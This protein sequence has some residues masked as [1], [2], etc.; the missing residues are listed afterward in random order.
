MTIECP[1]CQTNNPD[2]VKFCGECGTR[3]KLSEEEPL[4]TRT[5]EAPRK[6]L[7]SG[8]LFARRFQIIEVLGQGGMGKVYRAED[9]KV[10]EEVALKVI[11]PEISTDKKTIERF[12]DEL[13]LARK[14]AHRNVCKMYD[15]NEFSGSYYITMEYIAGQDLKALIRQT[16][17]LTIGKA[18]SVAGQVCEG[19]IEAHRLGIIHR[20]LKPSNIMID[21]EGNARIMDFGIARSLTAKR[22]TGSGMMLGTPEYMSPEQVDGKE[23]DQCSDI[24][25]MG[26]IL[27]EM[28]T[29]RVPFAGDTALSIAVKQKSESPMDPSEYNIRIPEDLSRLI[30]KCL[31]KTISSRFQ[32]AEQI[33]AELSNIDSDLT[34]TERTSIKKEPDTKERQDSEW[35]NSIAVLPFVDLSPQ[36]DQ[37]YFCDGMAE[38]L[39]NSLTKI[40][41]LRVVARTSAFAFKGE[42][43]DIREIGQK[44]NVKTVLEGS[45]RKAGNKL[46]IMAQLINIEDGFHIWS[47]KYDRD[48]DDV[49]AIQD[50][51]SLAIVDNLKGKLL[52]EEKAKLLKR[53]AVDVEAY[54]L[55]LKGLYF[56]NKRTKEGMEKGMKHFEQA[57]ELDPSYAQAYS[58]LADSFTLLSFWSFLP[59]KE[60]FPKAKALAEKALEIDGSLAEAHVSLAYIIFCYEWDWAAVEKEFKMA[61]QLNPGLA[62]AHHWYS[63]YLSA[64][65]R[66]EEALFEIKKALDLDPMSLMINMNVGTIYHHMRHYDKAVEVLQ[67]TIEMNP[68]FGQ[69]YYSLA[70][71]YSAMGKYT[72]SVSASLTAKKQGILW[73]DAVLGLAYGR[74][75]QK[76]KARALLKELKVLSKTRFVPP[77]NFAAI[78]VGLG[79]IDTAFEWIDKGFDEHETVMPFYKVAPDF[80]NYRSDP[81]FEK[82][83]K[84]LN[85]V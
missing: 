18:L 38:E 6:P 67:K 56:W 10:H 24:Y 34:T 69:A 15:L 43:A 47:D 8:D 55:Y 60:G 37:E 16:G 65:E 26:I 73:A 3:F 81:R 13:K 52:G 74:A 4:H 11:N 70:K 62:N 12:R 79:E 42:K 1:K 21:R 14:I 82:L 9:K 40:E 44:L 28:V 83:L 58:G 80:D 77:V 23:V 30:L 22:R 51:I 31:N 53:Q 48:M 46:R 45:V 54:K 75:G 66:H 25:S 68:N 59:P 35:K 5:L 33:L 2:T 64:M 57:I 39:I 41:D 29:G 19:L 85:L 49:F 32:S 84:K 17:Q 27:Y 36:E 76:D 78:Y 20:D 50:E 71:V 7:T 72:E 61:I 63:I